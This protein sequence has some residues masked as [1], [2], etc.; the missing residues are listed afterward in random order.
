MQ[1]LWMGL[2]FLLVIGQPVKVS[3]AAEISNKEEREHRTDSNPAPENPRSVPQGQTQHPPLRYTKPAG[4]GTVIGI[5]VADVPLRGGDSCVADTAAT[6]S[7]T[8]TLVMLAP[9]DHAG[10]TSVEQPM[11]FWHLSRPVTCPIE[12]TIIDDAS[13]RPLL[14]ISIHP[15][16][17]PGIH[18][19]PLPDHALNLRLGVRYQWSVALVPDPN[20]RAKDLVVSAP[21]ERIELSPTLQAELQ[22]SNSIALPRVY[23]AAGLWY[24]A[25][26]ALLA[27][28]KSNPH[29]T[30]WQQQQASLLAQGG[31]QTLIPTAAVVLSTTEH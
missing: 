26:T 18:S 30:E 3:F 17:A 8:P 29:E 11:L 2:A 14:E 20:D 19:L 1:I 10:R 13:D 25:L 28:R 6:R 22:Q 4:T 27:Q 7:D 23:A 31:L 5:L 16:H 21:F 24:D 9:T 12:V 15:P